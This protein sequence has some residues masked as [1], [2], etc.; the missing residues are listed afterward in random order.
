M[1]TFVKGMFFPLGGMLLAVALLAGCS[2]KKDFSTFNSGDE[3]RISAGAASISVGSTK[4]DIMRPTRAGDGAIQAGHTSDLDVAFA[5]LDEGAAGAYPA[6][7]SGASALNAT[8]KG[9]LASTDADTTDIVFA[10]KQ[11]Y[12]SSGKGTKLVGWYPRGTF[13]SGVVTVAIDG[14]SDILLTQELEGNKVDGS[15]FGQTGKIFNFDHQLT[16]LK[17]AVYAAD[18]DAK[19]VW[20]NITSIK[21]KDQAENCEI[22]LPATVVFSTALKDM[23]IVAKKYSDGTAVD[24]SGDG[25]VVGV[26]EANKVECGYALIPPVKPDGALTLVL[27][28]AVGGQKEVSISLPKAA[29]GTT[30]LGFEVGKAYEIRLI[31]TVSEIKPT[32]TITDWIEVSDPVEIPL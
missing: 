5:R 8:W 10:T 18:A 16:W 6:D 27:D 30:V 25:L 23:N 3:I 29:D 7:Y 19:D 20:G 14:D 28:T 1:K 2:K 24:Y 31:F 11:Y 22:T 15:R 26:A 21:L 17:F 32:A 13:N 9:T 4:S 12:L